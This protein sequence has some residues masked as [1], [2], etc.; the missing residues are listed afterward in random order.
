MKQKNLVIQNVYIKELNY[1]S[2][3]TP[4]VFYQG[5]T[6]KPEL[7]LNF[8]YSKIDEELYEVV[9]MMN[10]DTLDQEGNAVNSIYTAQAGL[11]R[12]S[13]FEAEELE[14]ILNINCPSILF[15][16]ARQEIDNIVHYSGFPSF[17]IQPVSFYQIY[18]NKKSETA[19]D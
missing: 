12:I 9:I 1:K 8:T 19:K 2:G 13:G 3:N 7:K 4:N 16:Y 11:F 5:L 18:E 10:V 14:Q 6:L 15:P 17:A